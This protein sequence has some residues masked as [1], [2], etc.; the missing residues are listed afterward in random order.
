M[1]YGFWGRVKER[2]PRVFSEKAYRRRPLAAWDAEWHELSVQARFFFL[3]V[4]K[5]PSKKQSAGSNPP[6]VLTDKF[7]AHVLKELV[8]AGF[9]EVQPARS[10]AFGDRVIAPEGLYDFATRVRTLR[11]LHLLADDQPSEFTKYVDQVYFGSEL[12]AVLFDVLRKA[13]IDDASPV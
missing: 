2:E 12:T 10:R 9:V 4:V 7:P 1:S 3:N 13:G 8:E 11:R 5:G 6:S